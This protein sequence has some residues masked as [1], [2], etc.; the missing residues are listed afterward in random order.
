MRLQRE[1]EQIL[2]ASKEAEDAAREMKAD[3]ERE[4]AR[5]AAAAASKEP[6]PAGN[7]SQTQPVPQPGTP[8]GPPP[9]ARSPPTSA[10]EGRGTPTR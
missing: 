7:G 2:L 9:G 5:K 6:K 3:A 1:C 8:S 4:A 10:V